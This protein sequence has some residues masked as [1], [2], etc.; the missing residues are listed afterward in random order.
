[1]GET[2][3][4]DFFT[5][6]SCFGLNSTSGIIFPKKGLFRAALGQLAGKWHPPRGSKHAHATRRS[7]AATFPCEDPNTAVYLLEKSRPAMLLAHA[8]VE[9]QVGA[10]ER[11]WRYS[12]S[13][14]C[15]PKATPS[16][17]LSG[18]CHIGGE[19]AES[20]GAAVATRRL[21]DAALHEP[22]ALEWTHF[23][24]AAARGHVNC[25]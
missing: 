3:L 6:G 25:R 17:K 7:T 24:W 19:S 8:C 13:V 4:N 15:E 12:A 20:G 23:L 21:D 22:D 11:C 18:P 5:G 14:T 10:A 2:L 16:A 9:G 1:M